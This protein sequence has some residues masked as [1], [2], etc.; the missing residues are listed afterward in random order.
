MLAKMDLPPSMAFSTDTVSWRDAMAQQSRILF[1]QKGEL[2]PVALFLLQDGSMAMVIADHGFVTEDDKDKFAFEMEMAVK[3]LKPIAMLHVSESWTVMLE[4]A[5]LTG[6][7]VGPK[8]L[9][10]MPDLKIPPSQHPD[11]K[12]II[13]YIFETKN[14]QQAMMVPILR[15]QDGVPTLGISDWLQM[16]VRGRFGGCLYKKEEMECQPTPN[17]MPTTP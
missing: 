1:A 3:L 6:M 12:E 16:D 15:P 2:E 11:R 10:N 17:A 13:S 14:V 4:P 8:I 5:V 7:D 9:K